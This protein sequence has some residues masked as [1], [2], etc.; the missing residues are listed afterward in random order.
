MTE[1]Q[2]PKTAEDMMTFIYS[3]DNHRSSNFLAGRESQLLRWIGEPVGGPIHGLNEATP[4]MSYDWH[5]IKAAH[6]GMMAIQNRLRIFYFIVKFTNLFVL[7][8]S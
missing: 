1:R 5:Q 3:G 7:L 6:S 2:Q 4:F 8:R